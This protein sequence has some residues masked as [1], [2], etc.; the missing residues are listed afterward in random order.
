MDGYEPHREIAKQRGYNKQPESL[1]LEHFT[2]TTA[3]EPIRM[4]DYAADIAVHPKTHA[5]FFQD[6]DASKPAKVKIYHIAS[7]ASF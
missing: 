5:F 6:F 2:L 1:G 3:G 7:E 4:H